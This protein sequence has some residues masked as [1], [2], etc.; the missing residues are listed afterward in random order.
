MALTNKYT[1]W[2]DYNKGE[3]VVA[4]LIIT[5]IDT[6]SFYLNG[7]EVKSYPRKEFVKYNPDWKAVENSE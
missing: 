6:V 2:T 3:F 4:D 1:I 7:R 5:L